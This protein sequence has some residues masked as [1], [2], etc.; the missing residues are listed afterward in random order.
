MRMAVPCLCPDRA[1][2]MGAVAVGIH[3]VAVIADGVRAVDIVDIAVEIVIQ[4]V[5]RHLVRVDPHLVD[6]I[7]MSVAHAGVDHGNDNVAGTDGEIPCLRGV[8]VGVVRAA[9]LSL[10][11]QAPQCPV[12]KRRI[13]GHPV[14]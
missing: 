13:V 8:D 5:V 1:S 4:A 6:Q 10:V 7:L 14:D 12:G 9:V 2:D 3:R 11:V